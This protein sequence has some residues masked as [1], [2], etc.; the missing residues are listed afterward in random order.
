MN[1]SDR[2]IVYEVCVTLAS[3]TQQCYLLIYFS[4]QSFPYR[5]FLECAKI[6][7]WS[8]K[9]LCNFALIEGNQMPLGSF[10]C[11]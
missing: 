4:V 10:M 11:I 9:K 8:Q 1:K 3:S 6:T 2:L 5:D 7:R